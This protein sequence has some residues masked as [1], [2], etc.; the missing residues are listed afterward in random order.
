MGQSKWRLATPASTQI[1]SQHAAVLLLLDSPA[2][3]AAAWVRTLKTLQAVES[4]N[5]C[6]LTIILW[7]GQFP[8]P[9]Q[10]FGLDNASQPP[11]H[12]PRHYVTT[13]Q[14]E[15]FRELASSKPYTC[16]PLHTPTVA[17]LSSLQKISSEMLVASNFDATS[18]STRR[19]VLRR[20]KQPHRC[21]PQGG[22]LASVPPQA[23]PQRPLM[24]P[25][26]CHLMQPHRCAPQGGSRLVCHVRQPHRCHLK[27]P[28]NC[29][30]KQPHNCHLVA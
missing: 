22:L 3:A 16:T 11:H 4:P 12:T 17:V 9:S 25:L 1:L 28:H 30:P 18:T 7:F 8:V 23:A 13:T 27:E 5:C 20:I 2:P 10:I 19:P 24:Q 6:T 26:N 29:Q 15:A 14:P 21:A